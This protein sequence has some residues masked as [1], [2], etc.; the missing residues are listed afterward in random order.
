MVRPPAAPSISTFV[1]FRFGGDDGARAVGAT[2]D[3]AS[4]VRPGASYGV[5]F[6]TTRSQQL[7]GGSSCAKGRAINPPEGPPGHVRDRIPSGLM[8]YCAGMIVI[9]GALVLASYGD[10][11]REQATARPVPSD[12]SRRE[13]Q[14]LPDGTRGLIIPRLFSQETGRF[15]RKTGRQ[16]STNGQS[17]RGIRDLDDFSKSK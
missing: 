1:I 12:G 9:V 4:P 3:D 17:P 5:S 16:L 13:S 11:R 15:S 8:F 7:A 2:D 10:H 6:A 14:H